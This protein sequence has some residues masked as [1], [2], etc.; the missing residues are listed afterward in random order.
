MKACVASIEFHHPVNGTKPS[1]PLAETSQLRWL[2]WLLIQKRLI[3]STVLYWCWINREGIC[4]RAKRNFRDMET[5][6]QDASETPFEM[7]HARRYE[8]VSTE[9]WYEPKR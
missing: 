9:R 6:L 7:G 4:T 1:E 8:F 2:E 5:D 3:I